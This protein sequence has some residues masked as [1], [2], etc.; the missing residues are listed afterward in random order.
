MRPDTPD[1]E[2]EDEV[3]AQADARATNA[4]SVEELNER[5]LETARQASLEERAREIAAREERENDLGFGAPIDEDED[6]DE[7]AYEDARNHAPPVEYDEEG[8]LTLRSKGKGR[9]N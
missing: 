1:L 9:A 8:R 2:A 7:D 5:L 4:I 3:R 6:E